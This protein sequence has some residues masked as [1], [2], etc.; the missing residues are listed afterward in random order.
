MSHHPKFQIS[1]LLTINLVS[2]RWQQYN[3]A[4]GNG[5][6]YIFKY[7]ISLVNVVITCS[8]KLI[9]ENGFDPMRCLV[10]C[11][12]R[13][14]E[15]LVLIFCKRCTSR[16]LLITLYLV[17]ELQK[18]LDT[19]EPEISHFQNI[20]SSSTTPRCLNLQAYASFIEHQWSIPCMSN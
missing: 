19:D 5:H 14:P 8:K 1:R 11:F 3:A 17:V 9:W 6:I 15:F 2:V 7:V 4:L 18:K 13:F 10:F 16:A 12:C 20:G